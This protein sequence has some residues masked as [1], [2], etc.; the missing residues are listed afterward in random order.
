MSDIDETV[1][2]VGAGLAGISASYYL[3]RNSIP[4]ILL[5]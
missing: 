5:E 4:H 1:I 3:S 2:I